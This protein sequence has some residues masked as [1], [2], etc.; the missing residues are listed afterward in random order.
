MNITLYIAFGIIRGRSW[1]VL[2]ADTGAHLYEAHDI[3]YE[4]LDC[5][6]V[7]LMQ[8]TEPTLLNVS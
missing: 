4:Y 7:I 8:Q 2:P 5:H 1:N 3:L 6:I